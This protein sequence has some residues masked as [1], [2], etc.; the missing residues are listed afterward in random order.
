M[1]RGVEN[2]DELA[3]ESR[4]LD[5]CNLVEEKTMRCWWEK[6][7]SVVWEAEFV[8]TNPKSWG[9]LVILV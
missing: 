4:F 8:Y 3:I 7:V 5:G 1:L 6:S 9:S 2:V